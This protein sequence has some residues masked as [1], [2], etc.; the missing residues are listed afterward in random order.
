[1]HFKGRIMQIAEL[2]YK[3]TG[4]QLLTDAVCFANNNQ[5]KQTA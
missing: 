5:K 2:E 4:I 1:M 3:N